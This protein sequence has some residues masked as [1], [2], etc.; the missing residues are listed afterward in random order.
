MYKV[1]LTIAAHRGIA[2]GHLI[3]NIISSLFYLNH[4]MTVVCTLKC[5]IS[6]DWHVLKIYQL[7]FFTELVFKKACIW[8]E[9]TTN[10]DVF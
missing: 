9:K 7:K 5:L 4:E 10:S 6:E 1:R 8:L 3:K 2:S